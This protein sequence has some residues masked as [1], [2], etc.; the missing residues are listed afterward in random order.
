MNSQPK[1]EEISAA[2]WR[3]GSWG[4]EC[5]EEGRCR[6]GRALGSLIFA[7]RADRCISR[8]IEPAHG[9]FICV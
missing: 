4:T 2:L 3:D 1:E 8:E 6:P 9:G 5:W 7:F